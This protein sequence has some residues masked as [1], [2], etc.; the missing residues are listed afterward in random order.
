MTGRLIAFE[1]GEGTGKSTQAARLARRIGALLTHEPGDTPLGAAIRR[2]LLDAADLDTVSGGAA[3]VASGGS[4]G[5]N[6]QLTTLL[7]QIGDSIKDL[8]RN[9]NGGNDQMTQMMFMMMMMGG[10][11]GGG[12]AAPAPQQPQYVEVVSSGKFGKKGW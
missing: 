9:N 6:D 1:G 12:A 11:G 2:I 8:A 5:T 4:S 10:F 7:T 3:R